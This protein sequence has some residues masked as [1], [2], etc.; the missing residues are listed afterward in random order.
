MES[1]EHGINVAV[2]F[3]TKRGRE[4]P[5]TWRG[6]PVIDGDVSDLRF[7]D[8]SPRI[9]GLRAKGKARGDESG[10]VQIAV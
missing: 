9:V 2:V 3:D 8:E 1:L 6:W 7:L 10:F 4:L 5:L